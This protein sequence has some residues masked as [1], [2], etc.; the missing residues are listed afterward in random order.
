MSSL[1]C[2]S[3]PTYL[4][5]N[6]VPFVQPILVNTSCLLEENLS[7]VLFG[8]KLYDAPSV[9]WGTRQCVRQRSPLMSSTLT[10][11]QPPWQPYLSSVLRSHGTF[12]LQCMFP[13]SKTYHVNQEGVVI[14]VNPHS[15]H[16]IFNTNTSIL[17]AVTFICEDSIWRMGWRRGEREASKH[18]STCAKGLC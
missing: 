15:A 7:L 17:Q 12:S 14:T 4:G 11:A 6:S 10:L 16:S 8:A 5:I 18:R 2:F 1:H 3:G 13:E 9:G